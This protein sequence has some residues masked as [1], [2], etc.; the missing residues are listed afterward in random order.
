MIKKNYQNQPSNNLTN[1]RFVSHGFFGNGLINLS[2][3]Q[4]HYKSKLHYLL[5][6]RSGR[7]DKR[8]DAFNSNYIADE[9]D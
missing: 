8:G 3:M 4:F 6:R 5:N 7:I 2:Q 1:N 9:E